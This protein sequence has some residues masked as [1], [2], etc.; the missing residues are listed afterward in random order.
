MRQRRKLNNEEGA[1]QAHLFL[2]AN[3]DFA[4]KSDDEI[5]EK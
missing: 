5:M 4:T 1:A 3:I 2:Q